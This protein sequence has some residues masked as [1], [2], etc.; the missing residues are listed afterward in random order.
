MLNDLQFEIA[1]RKYLIAR[2]EPVLKKVGEAVQKERGKFE[3]RKSEISAYETA[4]EAHDAYGYGDITKEEYHAIVEGMS[5]EAPMTARSAAEDEIKLIL[6]RL[7]R[8]IKDFEWEMLPD[9]ERDRIRES[10]EKFKADLGNRARAPT[11]CWD[12]PGGKLYGP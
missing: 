6:G 3:A 4:E 7:R 2:L 9:V 8:E 11:G 5:I 12:A 1:W 10:N